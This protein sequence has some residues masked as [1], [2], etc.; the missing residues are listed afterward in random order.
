MADGALSAATTGTVAEQQGAGFP[1]FKTETFPSQLFW[2]ALSFAVLFVV[3]WRIAGPRINAVITSR[4]HVI[5]EDIAAADK[6]RGDAEA[7]SAAYQMALAGARARAQTLAQDNRQKLNAEM[8][9]AKADAE[10]EAQRAMAEADRRI[11][12]TRSE[13]QTHM[14]K[15][16]EEAAIAIVARLTGDSVT[17]ADAARAVKEA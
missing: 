9:K 15:A 17:P 8:A 2:L 5:N 7:A 10:A 6:A 11:A 12:A 16:A 13:A 1:P 3:L 4:R 14:I